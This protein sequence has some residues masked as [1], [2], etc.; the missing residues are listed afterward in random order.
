MRR[1]DQLELPISVPNWTVV[2]DRYR[3]GLRVWPHPRAKR[4]QIEASVSLTALTP[5]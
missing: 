4:V 1:R 3:A 5:S 2:N